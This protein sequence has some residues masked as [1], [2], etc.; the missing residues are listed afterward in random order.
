MERV[1]NFDDSAFDVNLCDFDDFIF[2][3]DCKIILDAKALNL[4]LADLNFE[5]I[6]MG[7]L[8]AETLKLLPE[9]VSIGLLHMQNIRDY[10]LI[11]VHD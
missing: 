8:V 7:D 4:F 1:N 10:W 2:L 5:P 3:R 6:L 11:A 9:D